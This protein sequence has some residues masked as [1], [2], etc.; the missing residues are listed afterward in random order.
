MTGRT[1]LPEQ[2]SQERN[3]KIGLPGQDNNQDRTAR[4]GQ[5]GYNRQDSHDR[6]DRQ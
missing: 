3:A 2:V 4:T 5:L 6:R 1:G